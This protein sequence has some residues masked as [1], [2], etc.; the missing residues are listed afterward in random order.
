M[1]FANSERGETQI[2]RVR[3]G[4]LVTPDTSRAHDIEAGYRLLCRDLRMENRLDP[5]CNRSQR[6]I[7]RDRA[8]SEV[9]EPKTV[10]EYEEVCD[11]RTKGAE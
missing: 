4:Y 8:D 2:Q 10:G 9:D 6:N 7:D 1:T 3:G 11:E 5:D